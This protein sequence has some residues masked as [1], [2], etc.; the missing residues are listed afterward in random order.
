MTIC[1][2]H[3]TKQD[4]YLAAS[5]LFCF[6]SAHLGA[7]IWMIMFGLRGCDLAVTHTY[8]RMKQRRLEADRQFSHSPVD[9]TSMLLLVFLTTY[10]SCMQ[11]YLLTN[12]KSWGMSL[13]LDNC[14]HSL[15]LWPTCMSQFTV[16]VVFH[17]W[18]DLRNST[19][20]L[21]DCL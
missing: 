11:L 4:H 18:A 5:N 15:A 1:C 10:I 12:L 20:M 21:G 7:Q 3:M 9:Y 17:Y 8:H 16:T 6:T 19:Q 14:S 13:F 2:E